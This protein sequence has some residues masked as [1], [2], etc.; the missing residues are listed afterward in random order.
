MRISFPFKPKNLLYYKIFIWSLKN[1]KFDGNLLIFLHKNVCH[2]EF[3]IIFFIFM[4]SMISMILFPR[5][6][7]AP[8][9]WS[10]MM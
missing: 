2:E 7:S 9:K 5:R 3:F 6:K 10:K 8:I 1:W 4:I